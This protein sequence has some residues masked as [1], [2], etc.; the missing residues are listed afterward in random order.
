MHDISTFMI[1]IELTIIKCCGLEATI[2]K[3]W[4]VL[5]QSGEI[6]PHRPHVKPS[7][8]SCQL[9]GTRLFIL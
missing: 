6:N 2:K 4:L 7:N 9:F 3:V 1:Y 5:G 8:S